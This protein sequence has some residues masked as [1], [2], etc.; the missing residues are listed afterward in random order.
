MRTVKLI[1]AAMIAGLLLGFFLIPADFGI[2]IGGRGTRTGGT[3][4]S[5]AGTLAAGT[6]AGDA[7]RIVTD[8][9]RRIA[10]LTVMEYDYKDAVNFKDGLKVGQISIPLPLTQKEA[11]M[12]YEGRIR[13][14]IDAK[15]MEIKADP[16]SDGSIRKVTVTLPETKILSHEMD[17]E[18]F[19]LILEKSGILNGISTEDYNLLETTAR[20]KIE[21]RVRN[22]D[23]FGRAEAR[24]K[25]VLTAYLAALHGSGVKVEFKK[26]ES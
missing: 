8:E 24:L 18:S 25:E 26:K 19:A 4:T 21:E 6:G 20:E 11:V 1:L 12:T 9:L 17:R 13:I 14:G 23:L 22:S 16:G 15:E 10:E 2:F 3:G 7:S 5:S